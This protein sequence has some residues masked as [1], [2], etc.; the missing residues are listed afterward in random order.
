MTVPLVYGGKEDYA[1]RLGS[2]PDLPA[3]VDLNLPTIAFS[4]MGL[5]YDPQRKL[6]SQ[7]QNFMKTTNNTSVNHMYNGVPYN[8]KFEVSFVVRNIEEG[9][10]IVEQILPWFNPDYTLTMDF[11]DTMNVVKNVPIILDNVSWVNDYEGTAKDK[12]RN[13]TWTLNFTMQT[14]FYGPVYTGGL[15]KQ[16]TANTFYYSEGAGDTISYMDLTL[17]NTG[18]LTYKPGETVYQ[19]HN[20]PLAN[21]V[22][23]VANFRTS[24]STAILSISNVQGKFTPGINVH[25]ALTNASWNVVAVPADV[26]LVSIKEVVTPPSANIGDDFGFTTTI[27]EF[28][29]IT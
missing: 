15:I 21:A 28:P 29:N 19:G 2:L 20:L 11:V 14:Y 3:A 9:T 18:L 25:G 22:G 10:Q 5:E 24:N 26:K 1:L 4:L 16:A 8:L 23:V 12:L 7:L 6:Q 27:T 13:I 17:A